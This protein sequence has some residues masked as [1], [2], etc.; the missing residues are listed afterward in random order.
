[1]TLLA[2]IFA[3]E[4]VTSTGSASAQALDLKGMNFIDGDTIKTIFAFLGCAVTGLFT[5]LK[6]KVSMDKKL[7]EQEDH[8]RT[9]IAEELKA[10]IVNDPLHVQHQGP[11]MTV[12]E[13]K[14][15]RCAL[16]KRIDEI[17][18][19]INRIFKKLNENDTRAEDRANL[20]H[21]RLDPVI[22]RVAANSAQL[23]LLKGMGK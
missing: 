9:K 7:S 16:E 13:C 14:Q 6:M 5:Y 3:A 19:A 12:G 11:Y 8:L 2:L 10:K 23:E 1:M 20:L 17:G 4:A 15:H 18:P 21:R 22:E